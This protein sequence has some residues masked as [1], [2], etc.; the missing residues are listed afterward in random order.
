MTTAQEPSIY[1]SSHG[2]LVFLFVMFLIQQIHAL[3]TWWVRIPIMV[4]QSFSRET[5]SYYL[6]SRTLG[7][8]T[9]VYSSKSYS[10]CEQSTLWAYF[11]SQICYH[12]KSDNKVAL[13]RQVWISKRLNGFTFSAFFHC[14]RCVLVKK[15]VVVKLSSLEAH[16]NKD[17][18][19]PINE[20]TGIC[21]VTLSN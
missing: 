5:L 15:D 19:K 17:L 2:G 10:P 9:A 16:S 12:D 6:Y 1:A 4:Y 14:I 11:F 13:K 21:S 20:E 7:S 8:V 3:D 18:S